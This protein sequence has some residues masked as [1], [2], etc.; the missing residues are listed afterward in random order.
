MSVRRGE[1]D[2]N[3]LTSCLNAVG[4]GTR[5][6]FEPKREERDLR[7]MKAP[8]C[9]WTAIGYSFGNLL[10]HTCIQLFALDPANPAGCI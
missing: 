10:T 7:R 4:S 3:T 6:R 5:S 9:A 1:Q 2:S 8:S